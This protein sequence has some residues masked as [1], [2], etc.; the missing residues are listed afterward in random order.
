MDEQFVIVDI[1]GHGEVEFPATMPQEEID[2]AARR[3]YFEANPNQTTAST[4]QFVKPGETDRLMDN[5]VGTALG[6]AKGAVGRGWEMAK[7]VVPGVVNIL[8]GPSSEDRFAA[9]QNLAGNMEKARSNPAYAVGAVPLVGPA[10][11]RAGESIGSGD[12][13]QMGA[14]LVD[15]ASVLGGSPMVR[16]GVR[17]G[18]TATGNA[19]SKVPA[20]PA[21][22]TAV[23]GATAVAKHPL[24]ATAGGAIIGWNHGG[25]IGAL[26]GAMGG[27]IAGR[28]LKALDKKTATPAAP[29]PP[30]PNPNAGGRLAPRSTP[31]IPTVNTAVREA[32]Q[33]LRTPVTPPAAPPVTPTKVADPGTVR[34]PATVDKATRTEA[35]LRTNQQNTAVVAGETKKAATTARRNRMATRDA[36]MESDV[37]DLRAELAKRRQHGV[38]GFTNLPRLSTEEL[39]R[40]DRVMREIE[41]RRQP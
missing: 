11:I 25:A 3:L 39:A 27:G 1:P 35:Q 10:I 32:V 18:V 8:K 14:G 38:G 24:T 21:V 28:L 36:A 15:A 19:L 29:P 7:G 16:Q 41:S 12:P 20:I 30:A 31:A 22:Q 37:V 33:E 5:P 40:I 23:R 6:M 34:R 4:E 17:A 13:E 9:Y 26:E 2:K